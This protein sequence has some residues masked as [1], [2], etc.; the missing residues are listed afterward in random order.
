[1]LA[2]LGVH[3]R[4]GEARLV[5]FVMA[6]AAIAPHVDHDVA[7]ELLAELDRD[8]AGEGHRFGIVAVDVEDRRLDA[9]GDV[10]RIGRGAREL[11]ARREAD[12][13]VDDEVD[14]AAGIVAADAREAEAFPDDALA[15]HRR[16]AMDQHGQDLLVLGRDRRAASAARGP[17]RARPDRPPRGATG[18]RPATYGR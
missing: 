4:L 15:R 2:D 8:L 12:L 17:C 10:R 18:W 1:M 11:R 16:V 5:A 7:L 3:Q 14:A 13:V 9:L 6:E